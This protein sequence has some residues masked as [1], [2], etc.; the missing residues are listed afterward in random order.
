MSN[1]SLFQILALMR[2]NTSFQDYPYHVQVQL[3]QCMTY[4]RCVSVL[5]LSL[6]CGRM[7]ECVS[8]RGGQLVYVARARVHVH[9]HPHA[10]SN[11]FAELLC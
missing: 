5:L 6:V 3:A 11:A 1:V 7:S 2:G 4:Q 8:A 10:V 9:D